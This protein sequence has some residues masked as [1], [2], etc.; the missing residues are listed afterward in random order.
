MLDFDYPA[1]SALVWVDPKRAVDNHNGQVRVV[2]TNAE[3]WTI[4]GT[5]DAA[6]TALKNILP[7]GYC[8][9]P[10][11]CEPG[12]IDNKYTFCRS[13]SLAPDDDWQTWWWSTN[14]DDVVMMQTFGDNDDPN[15][16]DAM[17]V[18]GQYSGAHH[19]IEFCLGP[20]APT[21]LPYTPG[22]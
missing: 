15:K 3:F 18:L 17:L 10:A 12:A 8:G 13:D 14:N 2:K 7:N 4:P 22:H 21:P 1:G 16:T 6:R 5:P 19:T 20:D 11:G 9:S